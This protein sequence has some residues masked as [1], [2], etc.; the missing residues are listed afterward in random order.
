MKILPVGTE[1]FHADRQPDGRTG[2]MKLK[3]AFSNFT[4]APTMHFVVWGTNSYYENYR[5]H[6]HWV[7]KF[8][9]YVF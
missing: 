9:F 8:R 2:M 5:K 7:D 4:N 1:L 6:M 3:V